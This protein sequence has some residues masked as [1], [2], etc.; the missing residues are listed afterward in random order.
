[1]NSTVNFSLNSEE[2]LYLAKLV[3]HALSFA[4]EENRPLKKEEIEK[5][6]LPKSDLLQEKRGAFVS[7][8]LNHPNHGKAL[9][10]CI[11]M[12][13]SPYPL[14]QTIASMA[15][16]AA[17][18][19]PRFYPIHEMELPY[20]AWEINILTPSTLCTDFSHI[21]LG[22]HGLIFELNEHKSVFLPHV[23][24]EEGW[25]LNQMLD[26]LALK[27]GLSEEAWKDEKARFF[28]FESLILT[29]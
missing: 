15:Y 13:E 28:Y 20:I 8:Y 7:Y 18:K 1:M 14:W 6:S 10:G 22:K 9:R 21:E 27:A 16:S 2:K 23:A 3:V 11:G 4:V 17:I 26:N 19:D 29:H 5:I 24:M 12:M 25:T